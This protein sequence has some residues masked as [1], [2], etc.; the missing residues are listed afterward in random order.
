MGVDRGSQVTKGQLIIKMDAPEL[1]AQ[2]N[3][4]TQSAG[5]AEGTQTEAERR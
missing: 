2:K 3:Q 5:A 1:V 4:S